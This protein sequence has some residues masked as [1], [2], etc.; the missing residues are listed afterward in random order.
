MAL[1]ARHILLEFPT[2]VEIT[3]AR[4]ETYAHIEQANWNNLVFRDARVDGL[5]TGHTDEAGYHIAATA[6]DH[7]MRL[8]AVVL[9]APTLMR[10]TELAEGLFGEGFSQYALMPVPWQQ[11]VPTTVAVYGGS[12]PDVSLETAAP[13]AVLLHRHAGEALSIAESITAK[14]FAPFAR[15]QPVGMLTVALNGHPLVE[16]PLLAADPVARASVFGRA[17]GYVRYT[18]GKMFHRA[19]TVFHGT[20]APAQ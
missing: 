14:P 2:A 20:Y 8:I 13:V 7:G 17:W 18:A 1:L 12:A 10:R 3:S 11:V 9:G 6:V 15:A 4:Y 19:P 5:K 16:T